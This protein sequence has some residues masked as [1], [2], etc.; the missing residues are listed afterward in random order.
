MA[1]RPVLASRRPER[2]FER[3]Y[4]EYVGDVYRYALAVTGNAS[5]AEDVA[6]TT[7]MNAYR[8]Y[9]RGERP[10]KAQNWLITIAHNV[11]RQRARQSSRRPSEVRFEEDVAEAIVPS[12]DAPTA[13]DIQRALGHLAFNQRAALV[14]RELEGRTHAEI[15]EALGLT[16]AATEMLVFRAR[17]ALR[18]QL[19]GSL[20]CD[21]AEAAIGRQRDGR[22]SRDER[23]ALRAHLRECEDCARIARRQRAQRSA[24]KALAAAPLPASLSSFIGGGGVA[25]VGGGGAAAVG[26]SL[27]LKAVAVTV[28]A[29]AVAGGGYEAAPQTVLPT[30]HRPAPGKP[31]HTP[32][33]ASAH[34]RAASA[35]AHAKHGVASATAHGA[36]RVTPARPLKPHKQTKHHVP[37]RRGSGSAPVTT[38]AG[39]KTHGHVQTTP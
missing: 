22:L 3:L 37:V 11:C 30:P 13:G 32:A 17:R 23:G 8:A 35:R 6:Q 26:T 16:I 7:F 24:W 38:P 12:E 4:Q 19:A 29:V 34:G 36:K 25:L 15:A 9:E 39:A 14:M 20:T 31:A 5:D 28:A 1:A 27:A 10:L 2:S 33:T 21:D 18:E